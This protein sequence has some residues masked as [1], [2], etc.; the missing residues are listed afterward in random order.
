MLRNCCFAG[1]LALGLMAC[2]PV[3]TERP[4][5]APGPALA[6]PA[7]AKQYRIVPEQSELRVLVY[8]EG[9]LA[10]LGHNHVIS[11]HALSGVVGLTET[12]AGSTLYLNLPV[13]SLEVD[14]P[15]LRDAEGDDFPGHLD[16][17]AVDGTRANMLGEKLLNAA[18]YPMIEIRSRSI[19]GNLP[20]LTVRAGITVRDQVALVD[21]P[22]RISVDDDRLVAEGAFDLSHSQLGLEPFS[23]ML[24]ALAVRDVMHVKFHIVGR[25]EKADGP[26]LLRDSAVV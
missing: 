14:R 8:R 17:S 3:T 23:V 16:A 10:S 18:Q 26:S 4:G 6:I 9:A 19:G 20:D 11:S 15:E 5:A 21:I 22:V 7:G 25:A 13:D 1:L 24:G 2:A 12:V